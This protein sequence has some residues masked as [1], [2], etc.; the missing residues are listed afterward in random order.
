MKIEKSRD[1]APLFA[2]LYQD[3]GKSEYCTVGNFCLQ[4]FMVAMWGWRYIGVCLYVISNYN[5]DELF[6]F[7]LRTVNI[8]IILLERDAV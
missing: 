7:G 6:F 8:N 2:A 1:V 3:G 5:A 4:T